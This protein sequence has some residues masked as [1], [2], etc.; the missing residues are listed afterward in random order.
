MSAATVRLPR[1]NAAGN[2]PAV[3]FARATLARK[4]IRD[5]RRV[6]LTQAELA[7]RAGIRPETLC[8]IEKGKTM[9]GPATFN[10]I[11]RA[12]ER[13]ERQYASDTAG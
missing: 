11:H 4:L 10:R 2:V 13:A 7:R 9:P 5:R 6:G 1:P 3:A 12:L 8:R